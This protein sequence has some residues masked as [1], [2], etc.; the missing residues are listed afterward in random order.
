MAEAATVA[1][2][3]VFPRTL[4]DRMTAETP[5]LQRSLHDQALNELDV[6]REWMLALG[7]RTEE[8]EV[9]S[10]LHVIATHRAADRHQHHP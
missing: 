9:A 6:A 5:E 3:C 10:L 1:E 7:R 8:E 4:L 2:I